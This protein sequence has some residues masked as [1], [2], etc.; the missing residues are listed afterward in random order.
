M[1]ADRPL[2]SPP[3]HIHG[4]EYSSQIGKVVQEK[5]STRPVPRSIQKTE[6][7][8][9][10]IKLVEKKSKNSIMDSLRPAENND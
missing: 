1:S 10:E 3:M 8:E 7:R 6:T 2:P 5:R 4:E 9:L